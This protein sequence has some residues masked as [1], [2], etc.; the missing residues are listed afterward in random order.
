MLSTCILFIHPYLMMWMRLLLFFIY[1]WGTQ[2]LKRLN[3]LLKVTQ[4]V[5]EMLGFNLTWTP[6]S[7]LFM[8]SLQLFI[9]VTTVTGGLTDPRSSSMR[10]QGWKLPLLMQP[11]LLVISQFPSI[12]HLR[13][14]WAGLP[15]SA[16]LNTILEAQLSEQIRVQKCSSMGWVWLI[17]FED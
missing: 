3:N 12:F 7:R 16:R 17:Q 13:E 9:Q 11:C 5:D 14:T 15:L 10:L 6:T 1:N 2:S 4:L 8:S